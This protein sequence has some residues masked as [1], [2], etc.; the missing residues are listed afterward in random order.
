MARKSTQQSAAI[1]ASA[2]D[3]RHNQSSASAP[4]RPSS[5][6]SSANLKSAQDPVSIANAVWQNYLDSTPQRV[7]LVD[8]FMAFLVVVAAFQ[9]L[10]CVIVGNFVWHAID[11]SRCTSR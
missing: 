7:K 3:P 5:T 2:A 4:A 1:P 11:G 6:T 10:Y 8:T 9:F